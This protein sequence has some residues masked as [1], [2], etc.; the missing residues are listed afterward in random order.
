[1]EKLELRGKIVNIADNV[2]EIKPYS[3]RNTTITLTSKKKFNVGDEV[4]VEYVDE[5]AKYKI[6]KI[7][8]KRE[9]FE[10]ENIFEN[11]NSFSVL[12]KGKDFSF[13]KDFFFYDTM[14]NRIKKDKFLKTIIFSDNSIMYD[15]DYYTN[16]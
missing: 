10:I 3:T 15:T 11:Q 13:M 12:F 2:L 8:S 1:M 7:K 14:L 6:T 4:K 9:V 5:I 16:F